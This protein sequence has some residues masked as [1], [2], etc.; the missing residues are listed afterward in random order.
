MAPPED[1]LYFVK[2]YQAGI[3]PIFAGR[4]AALARSEGKMLNIIRGYSSYDE[5]VRLYKLSGGL[6]NED[7]T[8]S[9]GSG[10]AAVP[11]TSWHEY[12][13]A[14]DITNSWAK[15]LDKD[16]ATK[17][18][19]TLIRFGL[20]KP[21]TR[22]NGKIILEDWHIQPIETAGQWDKQKYTPEANGEMDICEFQKLTGIDADG[23]NGPD[24][25]AKA[26]EVLETIHHILGI[27]HY[28]NTQE[29][30]TSVTKSPSYWLSKLYQEPYLDAYTMAIVKKMR[31][32]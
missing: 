14:A 27:P 32:E 13:L 6:Q 16:A 2:S 31:G 5:Q 26:K 20:F 11:N 4:L 17:K 29:V 15:E 10:Y 1:W 30:I 8:W 24:T 21:L 25:K 22:G 12:R 18:Q 19:I 28:K 7:G 3:D 9:G 23:K